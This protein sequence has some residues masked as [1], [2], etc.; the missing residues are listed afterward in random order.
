[1]TSSTNGQPVLVSGENEQA[2]EWHSIDSAPWMQVIW[3]RNQQMD[4]PVKATR[5]LVTDNGV[6]PDRSFFTTVFTYDEV[7]PTPS[8]QLVCPTEWKPCEEE[9]S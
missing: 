3:V 4:K 5:G 1:M 9:K 6:H 8:G 2:D 7:M